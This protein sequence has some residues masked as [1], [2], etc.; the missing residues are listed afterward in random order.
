MIGKLA[1]PDTTYEKNLDPG[2][3]QFFFFSFDININIIDKLI[4]FFLT[5]YCMKSLILEVF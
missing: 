2:P 4:L 3:S 1:D 5:K